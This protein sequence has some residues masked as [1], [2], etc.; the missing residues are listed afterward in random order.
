M[1]FHDKHGGQVIAGL[2][3]PDA[4]Q[5]RNFKAFL[6]YSVK[7]VLGSAKKVSREG[8]NSCYSDRR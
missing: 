3:N 2:W 1:F 6:G 8:R 5:H 7:P 4:L